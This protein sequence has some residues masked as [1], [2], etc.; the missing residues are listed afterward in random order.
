MDNDDIAAQAV[1]F[2]MAG[3][4]GISSLSC[5]TLYELA[6]NPD[7]QKKL[8]IEINESF[9]ENNGKLSYEQVQKMK[10]LDM[11]VSESNRKWTIGTFLDRICGIPITLRSGDKEVTIPKGMPIQIPV[12]GFH[13]DPKYFPNPDKFDPERFDP[14]KNTIVPGTYLPFGN[15]PRNCIGKNIRPFGL[16]DDIINFLD[17]RFTFC[18]NGIEN[19]CMPHF[20]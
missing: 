15:G 5:F 10:Y 8:L 2:F 1:L 6:I 4:A 11:V 18:F 17:F 14:M 7:I 13:S 12:A 16:K 20:T 19:S 9:E 3:L